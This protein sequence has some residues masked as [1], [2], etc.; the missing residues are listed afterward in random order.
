MAEENKTPTLYDF[1]EDQY[2][3]SDL[4]R[5]VDSG[6]D[7]Y[8]SRLKNGE[9][10]DTEIRQAVSDL[11]SGIGDGTVTFKNN[12][13]H[14][15]RGRYHNNQDKDKDVYGWAAN[16][17]Y[18][19]MLKL[20]KYET[21][22]D[23]SK[24]EWDNKSLSRALIS[25]LFNSNT[26]N[27]GYFQAL[28]PYTDETSTTRGT[29]NRSNEI[30][31]W[32]NNKINDNL[33]S[34]YSGSDDDKERYLRYV[35]DV[36]S[37]LQDGVQPEDYYYLSRLFPD[38]PWDEMFKTD[39]SKPKQES[40]QQE[41]SQEQENS[42]E[43]QD[44]STQSQPVSFVLDSDAKYGNW[45]YDQIVDAINGMDDST[46]LSYL[47]SAI[48]NL[49]GNFGKDQVFSKAQGVSIPSRFLIQNIIAKM[50]ADKKLVQ[51][52]NNSNIYYIPDLLDSSA[53]SG[54][55]YDISNNTLYKDKV[56]NIPQLQQYFTT[57]EF[58]KKG[59]I[60]KAQRG[61]RFNDNANWFSGVYSAQRQHLLDMLRNNPNFYLWVNEMQDKHS[62]LYH[63]AG[64]N[65]QDVA[66]NDETV[67]EYQDAYKK[68][69]G[70]EWKDNQL[71]YNSLGIKNA[72]DLGMFNTE[73]IRTSGDWADE[74]YVSDSLYSG[75]TDFRRILGRVGDYTPE[76]LE[77]TKKEMQEAGYEM[78]EGDDGYYRLRYNL[79]P[80]AGIPSIGDLAKDPKDVD[81]SQVNQAISD[82]LEDQLSSYVDR[83]PGE[84]TDPNEV[85]RIGQLI[86]EIAPDILGMGRLFASLNTNNK[87]AKTLRRSLKP[88][89]KDTYERYSPITGAFSEMQLRNRQAAELRRQVARP[90]TSDASLQLAAQLDANRQ[91]RDLEYQGFLADDKEIKRT[92]AEALARQEDNMARR[93]EVANFNRASINQTNREIDQLEATRL[94]Q[95]WQS[96][97][98][99]LKGVEDRFR[100][101]LAENKRRRQNLSTQYASTAYQEALQNYNKLYKAK[102]PD[103]TTESMLA[104][105]EYTDKIQE[106]KQRYNYDLFNIMEGQ[107]LSNPYRRR[108]PLTYDEILY[109]KKGGSLRPSIIRLINKVISDENNS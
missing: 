92:Q 91:A 12:R 97:D 77:A 18:G 30:L 73:G 80:R 1:Y 4:E 86:G 83:T 45:T 107:Y 66:Y 23:T 93:S 19:K 58:K 43:S 100:I 63:N 74:D 41:D 55:Y 13:F 17:I 3:F 33:F 40:T 20:N 50:I 90:F 68:G 75:I 60:I 54:Y 78:Y 22:K 49:N 24:K 59:G 7:S 9:K 87:V 95:N 67:K 88:I 26:V 10:Y 62:R 31:N 25:D 27:Y 103:A 69:F 57:A 84:F 2:R 32:I 99:Y 29:I 38:I 70:D 85:S 101:T 21:P 108:T 39:F 42:E 28:D 48:N 5:S 79:Q 102:H 51:D 11:M 71:G 16:Y 81:L 36:K 8:I 35:D 76:E 82:N 94:K 105:P 98:N 37:R 72:A 34:Q 61:I 53:E 47:N 56:S 106:L 52:S 109:S 6:L 96:V 65:W 64:D 104:D 14:D 44:S 89:L 46:L 15:S